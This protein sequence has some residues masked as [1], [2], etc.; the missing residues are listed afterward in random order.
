MKE[1]RLATA[2][3][4][5]AMATLI[6]QTV[7]GEE[8]AELRGEVVKI[9]DIVQNEPAF[10][11]KMVV[12]EGNIDTECPSGCWFIVNDQTAS[13]YVDILPSNFVIPQKRGSR[14]KVYGKVTARD[15][16][17]MIIGKMVEIGGEIYQ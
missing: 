9:Q 2:L 8:P 3:I 12:I 13:I 11:G 17:P 4:L 5:M 14:A 1:N 6:L 16:D 7:S 10:D 15:G